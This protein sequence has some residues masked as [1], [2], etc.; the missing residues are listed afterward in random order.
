MSVGKNIFRGIIK[1]LAYLFFR[2]K[3]EYLD[4]SVKD[5]KEPVIFICNHTSHYDGALVSAVLSKWKPCILIAKDWADKKN[6]GALFRLYGSVPVNR[7]EMDT[8]WFFEA[9][10]RMESGENFLIFPEGHTSKGEMD[11]FQSGFAIL[12]EKM[13]APIITCAVK[14]KYKF[15]F[16][17]R[18]HVVI[19]KA[20][21]TECPEDMRKSIYAKGFAKEMRGEVQGLKDRLAKGE[22]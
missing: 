2:P 13:Q 1:G 22:L 14:G 17:E 10:K 9:Q 4:K 15:I 7:H 12:A 5:I 20:Y 16:G 19:G 8:K 3:V 6:V 11:S 21:R 18:M